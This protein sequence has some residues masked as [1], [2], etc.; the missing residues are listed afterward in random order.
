MRWSRKEI[1]NEVKYK[2][3]LSKGLT[4][5]PWEEEVEEETEHLPAIGNTDGEDGGEPSG[6]RTRNSPR[7]ARM[8]DIKVLLEEATERGAQAAFRLMR[9]QEV[10]RARSPS[11]GDSRR[12]ERENSIGSSHAPQRQLPKPPKEAQ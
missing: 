4:G 7:Y 8:E 12:R 10:A 3:D 11:P 1:L 9:E 5:R 2:E 6:N